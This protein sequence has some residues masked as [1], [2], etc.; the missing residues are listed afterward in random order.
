MEHNLKNQYRIAM[1]AEMIHTAS[2]IHDD[3]IDEAGTRR[4]VPTVNVKWG[5]KRVSV[6][7]VD[8]HQLPRLCWAATAFWRAQR[9]CC[10]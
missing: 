6:C 5:N 10:A 1:V 2:L 7:L 8:V 4:G 9:S 3:V